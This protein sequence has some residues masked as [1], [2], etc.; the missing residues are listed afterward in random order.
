MAQ[1]RHIKIK[2]LKAFLGN[3]GFSKKWL[4]SF[5]VLLAVYLLV[6]GNYGFYSQFKTWKESSELQQEIE[7]QKAQHQWL[8]QEKDSLEHDLA[9]IEKEAREKYMMGKKDEVIIKIRKR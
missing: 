4:W 2:I 1:K 5:A 3:P 6:A 9:R 8:E 7:R